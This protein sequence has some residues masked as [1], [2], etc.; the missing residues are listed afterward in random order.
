MPRWVF[1]PD[2]QGGLG[3]PS[4]PSG[5]IISET[6]EPAPD[7]VSRA[8][9]AAIANAALENIHVAADERVLIDAHQCGELS[10]A[11]FLAHA[12]TLAERKAAT[13]DD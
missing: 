8:I 5:T 7:V 13:G 1:W 2:T 11:Q 6:S 9:D 12:R 3:A 10:D 4:P